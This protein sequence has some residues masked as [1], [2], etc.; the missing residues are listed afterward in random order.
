MYHPS[1]KTA[2]LEKPIPQSGKSKVASEPDER[3]EV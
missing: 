1:G 3:M 2:V